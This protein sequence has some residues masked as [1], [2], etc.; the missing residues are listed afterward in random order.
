M[1]F[2]HDAKTSSAGR[3]FVPADNLKVVLCIRIR[4]TLAPR[5]V[6]GAAHEEL[7]CIDIAF[8]DEDASQTVEATGIVG[9]DE[10]RL[11]EATLRVDEQT[12]LGRLAGLDDLPVVEHIG[13][14]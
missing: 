10:E 12:I 1:V 6:N 7:R 13:V 4:D 5:V 9:I 2:D 14:L 3:P 8:V 11:E